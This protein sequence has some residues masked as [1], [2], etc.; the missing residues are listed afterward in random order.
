M[1]DQDVERVEYTVDNVAPGKDSVA[2]HCTDGTIFYLS[3]GECE[4]MTCIHA[5]GSNERVVEE[6]GKRIFYL[7]YGTTSILS[8]WANEWP[9]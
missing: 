1:E 7:T 3:V 6:G 9:G 5:T 2:V 8:K 4:S